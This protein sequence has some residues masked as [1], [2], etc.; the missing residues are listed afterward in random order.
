M[1]SLLALA[2]TGQF[3][4]NTGT[5][6]YSG[7]PYNSATGYNLTASAIARNYGQG[8]WA[9]PVGNPKTI[10][11]PRGPVTNDFTGRVL[12][13]NTARRRVT[14]ELTDGEIVILHYHPQ[15]IWLNSKGEKKDLEIHVGETSIHY[16]SGTI[17][18]F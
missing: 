2:I 9:P 4:G 3:L 13:Y 6:I 17:K 18:V 12:E 11:P 7:V 5:F 15:T 1:I 16:D 8:Y 10:I 14:L